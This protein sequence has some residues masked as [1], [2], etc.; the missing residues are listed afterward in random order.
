MLNFSKIYTLYVPQ[1]GTFL[2][3]FLLLLL[4]KSLQLNLARQFGVGLL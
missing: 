4:T 2:N 1:N 3:G